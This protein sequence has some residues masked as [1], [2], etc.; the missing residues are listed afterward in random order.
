MNEN[1]H[2]PE[3]FILILRFKNA[4][5]IEAGINYGSKDRGCRNLCLTHDLMHLY[6]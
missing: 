5:I 4:G 1:Y 3:I 6:F 2:I